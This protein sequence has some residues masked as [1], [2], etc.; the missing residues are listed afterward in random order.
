MIVN[1]NSIVQN[2]IEIKSGIMKHVNVHI[3]II[4]RAKKIIAAILAHVF[5][6]IG[7]SVIECDE[8]ITVMDIVSTKMTNTIA[9]STSASHSKK[10]RDC[11]ILHTILL[12]IILLLIIIIILL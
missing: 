2:V 6:R 11:Y 12:A 3:K 9:T 5:V 8:I 7:N 1:A 10:V 4:I